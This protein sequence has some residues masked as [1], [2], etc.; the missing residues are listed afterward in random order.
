MIARVPFTK[1]VCGGGEEVGRGWGRERGARRDRKP[2]RGGHACARHAS[3]AARPRLSH[4][5]RL[6]YA[7]EEGGKGGEAKVGLG[8][9]GLEGGEVRAVGVVAHVLQPC[10]RGGERAA[11]AARTREGV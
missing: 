3:A 7:L 1:E 10:D 8:D 4:L 2:W 9:I 11:A 5:H 6:L